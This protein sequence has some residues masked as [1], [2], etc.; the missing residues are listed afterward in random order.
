M[1][2]TPFQLRALKIYRD[3]NA[4]GYSIARGCRLSVQGWFVIVIVAGG[5]SA[6]LAIISPVGAA[7]CAGIVLGALLRDFRAL[8][9][10]KRLWPVNREIIDW[11]RVDALIGD[12]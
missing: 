6:L 8:V 2:P 12:R 5:L 1:Q 11:S 7:L 10:A 3:Y 9:T 4:N